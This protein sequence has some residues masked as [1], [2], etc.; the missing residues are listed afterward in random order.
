VVP[1]VGVGTYLDD[2]TDTD[3]VD[4]EAVGRALESGVNVVDTAI[5]YR[6]QRSERAVGA[7]ASGAVFA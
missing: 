5:N 7:A 1:S 3:D 6:C 2:P 4:R